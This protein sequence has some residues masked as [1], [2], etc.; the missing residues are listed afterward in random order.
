M[1]S[2]RCSKNQRGNDRDVTR[3]TG[4]DDGDDLVAAGHEELE[5]LRVPKQTRSQGPAKG[6]ENKKQMEGVPQRRSDHPSFLYS[7]SEIQNV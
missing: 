1:T 6:S 3:V 5:P 7:T 2:I 4:F